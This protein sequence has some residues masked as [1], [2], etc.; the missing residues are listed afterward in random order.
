MQK[1]TRDELAAKHRGLL[2][3]GNPMDA[4][5]SRSRV[6]EFAFEVGDGW[7]HIVD[8]LLESLAQVV[9]TMPNDECEL[10]C[11]QQIKEKFGELRVYCEPRNAPISAAVAEAALRANCT[12]EAC[13]AFGIPRRFGTYV[14]V[15]CRACAAELA[16]DR[17]RSTLGVPPRG[18]S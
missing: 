9:T 17:V 12:C 6:C 14:A 2:S 5:R 4:I 15:R 13:G 3:R 1:L 8:T 10:F 7:L 18:E 16:S 11:I